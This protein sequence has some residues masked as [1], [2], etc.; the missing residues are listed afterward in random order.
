VQIFHIALA[1]E[2]S[3]ARALGHYGTSTLGRTLEEEGFIHASRREQVADVHR[4]FYQEVRQPLLL[5]TIETERLTSPWRNDPVGEDTYPH[6][7][8]PLNVDAVLSAQPLN[9]RGGTDPFLVIFFREAMVR[10]LMALAVM[11]AAFVGANLGGRSE[12][13]WGPFVGAVGGLLLGGAVVVGVVR[14]RRQRL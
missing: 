10:M 6:I 8:G 2:W 13:E 1:S 12:S 11:S 5:L 7:Y 3:E 9:R 4:S 14:R